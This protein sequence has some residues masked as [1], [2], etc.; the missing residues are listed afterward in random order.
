MKQEDSAV[1]AILERYKVWMH[2]IRTRDLEAI[3]DIYADDASYMPLGRPVF[4]GKKALR[5]IWAAYLQRDGFT[6]TYLPKVH[7]SESGDMAYDIGQYRITMNKDGHPVAFEGKYVVV[8]KRV[9][10]YWKAAVDI[11]NDNGAPG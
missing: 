10:Q 5:E 6:A 3:L 11:D 8:W 2:A 9:G 1:S 4:T 7:L